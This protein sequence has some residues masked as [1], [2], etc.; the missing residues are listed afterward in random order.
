MSARVDLVQVRKL[1]D[2]ATPGPWEAT[3]DLHQRGEQDHGVWADSTHQYIGVGDIHLAVQPAEVYA[4]EA[5]DVE[6]IAAARTVVPALLD[7][8]AGWQRW[9][10]EHADDAS[11][12]AAG[13][14]EQRT[15]AEAAEE[16]VAKA[17]AALLDA[18][19]RLRMLAERTDDYG[20][21]GMRTR[22][23]REFQTIAHAVESL[24][25]QR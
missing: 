3:H 9:A 2:A 25:A 21:E 5:A 15:R 7:E 16:K 19:H 17:A 10:T 11:N 8:I 12:Q 18:E 13:A 4:Q 6:F 22:L 24:G 20:P 14:R 23:T 1:A